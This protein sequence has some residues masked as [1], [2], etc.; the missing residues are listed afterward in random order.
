[1]SSSNTETS[2]SWVCLKGIEVT[3][4]PFLVQLAQVQMFKDDIPRSATPLLFPSR[5]SS[6][7][8]LTVGIVSRV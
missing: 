7:A 2:S 5:V 8:P 1:M 3:P 4:P 6:F